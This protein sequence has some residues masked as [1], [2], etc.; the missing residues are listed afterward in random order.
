[1]VVVL[2]GGDHQ[3]ITWLNVAA[4]D[5]T[6]YR[7]ALPAD[8]AF[9]VDGRDKFKP[10]KAKPDKVDFSFEFPVQSGSTLKVEFSMLVTATITIPLSG[11]LPETVATVSGAKSATLNVTG[12]PGGTVRVSG[13]GAK[14]SHIKPKYQWGKNKKVTVIPMDT[15]RLPMPNLHNVGQDLDLLGA[16][17]L[18]IGGS[19]GSGPVSHPKSGDANFIPSSHNRGYDVVSHSKYSEVLKS[20]SKKTRLHLAGPKC[21]DNF[22][23]AKPITKQQKNIPPDKQD[24]KLFGEMCALGLN[25]LASENQKFPAGLG[26]LVWQGG[27][28]MDDW[29]VDSIFWFGNEWLSC[30]PDAQ[31][32]DPDGNALYACVRAIDS[33][34]A[35]DVDTVKWSVSLLEL[36]G[37]RS[38]EEVSFLRA[39]PSSA[40]LR[41]GPKPVPEMLAEMPAEFRLE[42]NYPNPFNPA[43][44]IQFDLPQSGIV[45]L[46]V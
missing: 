21:L 42:Q 17:P 10:V 37:V 2:A 38:M 46:T 7:T 34:F 15:L 19:S 39:N 29:S 45:T 5:T 24:N 30:D 33:A 23:N 18:V 6:K 35:G 8:W 43:T 28:Y 25:L 32:L 11:V 41:T 1:M 13:R 3:S 27:G 4:N 12:S 22:D 26:Q 40:P 44:T 14:G 20:L 9:A 31:T 36:T 16:F